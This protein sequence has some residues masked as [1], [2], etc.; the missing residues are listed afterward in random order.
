MK[1]RLVVISLATSAAALA[2]DG[3]D[4]AGTSATLAR[5][6]R[7]FGSTIGSAR[8]AVEDARRVLGSGDV[9]T[10]R[11]RLA[12]AQE[13]LERAPAIADQLLSVN[14]NVL[15]QPFEG[16]VESIVPGDRTFTDYYAPANEVGVVWNDPDLGIPWPM[17]EGDAVL[18]PK[19]RAHPRFRDIDPSRL[20]RYA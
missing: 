14:A 7:S 12:S 2:D 9:A 8:S 6:A 1:K 3:S 17:S 13:A 5:A 11:E 20:P 4:G 16:D 19:D 15:V 18:S 10:A